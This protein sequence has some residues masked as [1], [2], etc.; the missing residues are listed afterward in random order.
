MRAFLG[1]FTGL[2]AALSLGRCAYNKQCY[3]NGV[4]RVVEN[5]KER[6]E[7]SPEAVAQHLQKLEEEKQK[8]LALQARY[9]AAAKRGKNGKARV[10]LFIPRGKNP[11]LANLSGQY[12][13]MLK[14]ALSGDT[15][16]ELIDQSLAEPV[17]SEIT[18]PTFTTSYADQ[19]RPLWAPAYI[20]ALR[21][22]G[23]FA[24][25]VVFT[26][27]S[28]KPMVGFYGKKGK[29]AGMIATEAVEFKSKLTSIYRYELH[30]VSAV[31]KSINSVAGAGFD[32]KLKMSGG[33]LTL[34]RNIK[35]DE[36]AIQNLAQQIKDKVNNTVTPALPTIAA[37]EE[38]QGQRAISAEALQAV[39][40]LKNLFK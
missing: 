9:D 22:K 18:R 12:Y 31:G 28:P 40:A 32:K 7:G 6:Y 36:S 23:F 19:Q 38:I 33:T 4:C 29:G 39:E 27:L 11:E 3:G 30:E 10:A 20:T 13:Q 14:S 16:I 37:I 2:I 25:I 24:D 1:I 8:K 21:D 15:H 35:Q 5:G 26:E 17:L 34:K